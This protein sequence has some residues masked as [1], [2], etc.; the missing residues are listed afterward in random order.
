MILEG[1]TEVI[2][3]MEGV[4]AMEVME[5]VRL[6]LIVNGLKLCKDKVEHRFTNHIL[7]S[8]ISTTP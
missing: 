6:S 3:I 5:S 2:L 1:L 7:L 4:E 8:I